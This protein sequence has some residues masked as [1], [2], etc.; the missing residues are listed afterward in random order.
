LGK[1]SA[2]RFDCSCIVKVPADMLHQRRRTHVKYHLSSRDGSEVDRGFAP[3]RAG[4][5]GQCNTRVLQ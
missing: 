2:S 3:A 4:S 5:G 1:A